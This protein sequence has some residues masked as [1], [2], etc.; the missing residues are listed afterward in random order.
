MA[1]S[2]NAAATA[3]PPPRGIGVVLTR[4]SSGRSTISKRMDDRR[5]SGVRTSASRAATT[6]ARRRSAGASSPTSRSADRREGRSTVAVAREPRNRE[7]STISRTSARSRL[8]A[9]SSRSRI[10]STIDRPID[11]HLVRPKPR[12]VVA[13][14]PIRIPDAVFGGASNG[15]A[16]LLTVIP[17]SSSR[18]SAS[19]PVTPERGHV[20]EQQV[21]VR[22]ARHHGRPARRAWRPGPG[23][24]RSSGAGPRGTSPGRPAWKRDGLAG[25]DVHERSALDAREDVPVDR[26]RERALR[27]P[28]SRRRPCPGRSL[29]RRR[30]PP[31]GPRRVLWVVVVTRSACGN[32]LGWTSAATRPAT[33]AMSTNSSAP[34]SWAMAAIRSKSQVA[35]VGRRAADDEL[36]PDLGAWASIAS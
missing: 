13:G 10:A 30:R 27:P 8:D 5:T 29:R 12:D 25:D 34:T 18:C 2:R 28:G 23:R 17:I 1:T 20:H 7:P 26:R 19:L 36:G 6:N 21:V 22:A 31:R 9:G 4:R 24:W 16:F 33:W 14:V 11:A 32:G 15:M 35:R 3:R